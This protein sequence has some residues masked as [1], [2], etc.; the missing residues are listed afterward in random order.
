ML[1]KRGINYK[2][3]LKWSPLIVLKGVLSQDSTRYFPYKLW[4][5]LFFSYL[6][7]SLYKF[8]RPRKLTRALYQYFPNSVFNL[9]GI[10]LKILWAIEVVGP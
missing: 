10:Y 3:S 7:T 5:S 4:V 1:A 9:K 6:D 8:I 2:N